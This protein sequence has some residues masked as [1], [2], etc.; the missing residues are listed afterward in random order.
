V[1]AVFVTTRSVAVMLIAACA[2]VLLVGLAVI[3]S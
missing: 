2:A 3:R 1:T